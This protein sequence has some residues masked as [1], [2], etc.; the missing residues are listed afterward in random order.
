MYS[1]MAFV[2]YVF[3]SIF[4]SNIYCIINIYN[5]SASLFGGGTVNKIP[6]ILALPLSSTDLSRFN[7]GAVTCRSP[8]VTT[9]CSKISNPIYCFTG[10]ISQCINLT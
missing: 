9:T 1:L 7:F 8:T 4:S 10:V 5:Y 6:Q 3:T 2:L